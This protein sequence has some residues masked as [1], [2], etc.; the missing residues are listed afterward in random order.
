MCSTPKTVQLDVLRIRI[1]LGKRQ[2]GQSGREGTLLEPNIS[3]DDPP[4]AQDVVFLRAERQL[5]P[6]FLGPQRRLGH[7]VSALGACS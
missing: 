1:G 7:R 2:T 3:G 4:L 6:C 5:Q